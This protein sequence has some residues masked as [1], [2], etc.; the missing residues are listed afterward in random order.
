MNKIFIYH[1]FFVSL[2]LLKKMIIRVMKKSINILVAVAMVCMA[3]LCGCK[4]RTNVVINGELA[5]AAFEGQQVYLVA[6]TQ[7]NDTIDSAMVTNGKFVFNTQ[8]GSPAIGKIFTPKLDDGKAYSGY[9]VLE[10]GT[11][12]VNLENDSLSG[13]PLNDSLFAYM[14]NDPERKHLTQALEQCM[15]AYYSATN[16][17]ERDAAMEAYIQ[18]DSAW[19]EYA[20]GK[21]MQGYKF[22]AHNILGAYFVYCYLQVDEEIDF[23]GLEELLADADEVVTTF[24]PIQKIRTRLHHEFNTSEGKHYVDFEGVDFADGQKTTLS[25]MMDNGKVTLIDFWAS[26]CGPC[27]QEISQ[28]LVRL[29]KEYKDKGLKIIGVDVWDKIPDH[30]KAVESLGIEYPQLI[31]T[32]SNATDLYGVYGIPTILLVDKDGTIVRRGIRGDEIEEAIL[33]LLAKE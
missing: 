32:T 13:T 20:K 28:N 4:S 25:A 15:S 19:A 23:Q 7:T 16:D 21:L 12:N 1:F 5:D 11:V 26:W 24:Y 29:Y 31:D 33:Q 30:K 8:L 2:H 17:N 14:T 22:N 3:V 6:I 18:A 10:N 27:R 9:L